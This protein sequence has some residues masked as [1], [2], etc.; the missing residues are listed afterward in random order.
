M[1]PCGTRAYTHSRGY[2]HFRRLAAFI[3][4][5]VPLAGSTQ[6]IFL[7]LARASQAN[8]KTPLRAQCHSRSSAVCVYKKLLGTFQL[9]S[10]LFISVLITN[11]Q[12]KLKEYWDRGAACSDGN[13]IFH[14]P[15][16]NFKVL[17]CHPHASERAQSNSGVLFN[18]VD[19]LSH[20]HTNNYIMHHLP[21]INKK[22]TLSGLCI[23]TFP[24]RIIISKQFMGAINKVEEQKGR[25]LPQYYVVSNNRKSGR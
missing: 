12:W 13:L 15:R 7:P 10:S 23:N 8:L 21:K 25:F 3:S 19:P 4:A 5:F 24:S 16:R 1:A 17:Q 9:L 14:K 20:T 11:Q 6:S 2:I 18:Y 22:K